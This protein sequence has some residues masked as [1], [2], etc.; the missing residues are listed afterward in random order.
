MRFLP[1]SLIAP[2]EALELVHRSEKFHDSSD[3]LL[4]IGDVVMLNSGGPKAVVI[5]IPDPATVTISWREKNDRVVEYE[6][7]RDCVHRIRVL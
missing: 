7:P 1:V 6:F 3:S 2:A 4:R 5:D